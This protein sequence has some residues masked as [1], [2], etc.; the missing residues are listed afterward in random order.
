MA[1]LLDRRVYKVLN[2]S[3]E[4]LAW[5]PKTVKPTKEDAEA[6][7]LNIAKG[8]LNQ[9]GVTQKVE[10]LTESPTNLPLPQ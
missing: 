10:R 2:E 1:D 3:V 6:T 8:A 5:T 7:A 4:E 9:A